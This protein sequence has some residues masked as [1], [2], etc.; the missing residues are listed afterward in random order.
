MKYGYEK[1]Y[2]NYRLVCSRGYDFSDIKLYADSRS[3]NQS[4]LTEK[5]LMAMTITFLTGE[6]T[7]ISSIIADTTNAMFSQN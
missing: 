6:L 4:K 2:S 7:I 5:R 1:N 3:W